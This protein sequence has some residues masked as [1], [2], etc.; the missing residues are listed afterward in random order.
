MPINERVTMVTKTLLLILN[1]KSIKNYSSFATCLK[2]IFLSR[3]FHKHFFGLDCKTGWVMSI[4]IHP[5]Q[6]DRAKA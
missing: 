4:L 5:T 6:M 1:I 2:I 3:T